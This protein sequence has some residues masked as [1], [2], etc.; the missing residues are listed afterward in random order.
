MNIIKELMAAGNRSDISDG[1]KELLIR[2]ADTINGL[3][4]DEHPDAERLDYL[5]DIGHF[6]LLKPDGMDY[7]LTIIKDNDKTVI[8]GDT[9][10]EVLD[11]SANFEWGGI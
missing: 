2:A 11:N 9:L 8:K 1:L 4:G 3:A 5:E 6:L 7:R 10:R